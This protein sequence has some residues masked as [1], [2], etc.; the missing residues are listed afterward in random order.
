M[1]TTDE[2]NKIYDQQMLDIFTTALEGG[3]NYWASVDAYH[4]SNEDGSDDIFGFYAK[5][6]EMEDN[7]NTVYLINREIIERGY[8]LATEDF[9]EKI[10]W[11]TD[12]PP[13]KDEFFKSRVIDY[14]C[15]WDFDAGDADCILQL[16]IFGEVIFG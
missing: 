14:D 10:S 15:P 9:R 4:W 2:I 8:K 1:L 12:Y 7:P 13:H 6:R 5:I 16:G 3:I 11:S